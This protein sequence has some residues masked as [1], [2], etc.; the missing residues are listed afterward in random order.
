MPRPQTLGIDFGTSNSAAGVTV[1]DRPWLVELEPGETT[2]PTAIFFDSDTKQMRIGRSATRALV[3]GDEGRFMR[4]LKSLLGTP[5]LYEKRRLGGVMMDFTD[6]IAHFLREVKTRA[7]TAT[8]LEFSHALSGRP[9]KFHSKDEARNARAEEDLRACYLKAG[10][11]DVRFLNEPEAALRAARPHPGIG[12]V[13]DIGGGTSDF[14]CFEQTA[15]GGSTILASH[16]LR[17]GGTDFDRQ[18]SI[19]H[20]MPHLGRGAMIRNSFGS[21]TLPAPSR[22]FN[23]LATWAMIPFLYSADS[24]RAAQD[25]A[26]NAEDPTQLT[27]LVRVLDEEL[28]HDLAF[29]TEAGKIRANSNGPHGE[30]AMIDLRLI[31]PGLAAPLTGTAL[32][33]TLAAMVDDI[34]AEAAETLRL[35]NIAPDA[36]DRCVM[37]GGSAL[38]SAVRDA[39]QTLCPNA[40]IETER[41]MTAVA[42]GLALAAQ[43]AVF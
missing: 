25:L 1:A 24:R 3:E 2:L 22:M 7:E 13:V 39:M 36:V 34:R 35:A 17:L 42:D 23:D 28:G 18:I 29:A 41:A 30:A 11:A 32:N 21:G 5:L 19:D 26:R 8:R 6:V 16:G 10:F 31:D 15:T 33:Q 38:L 20:V 27:R 9:V 40:E 37:V 43:D 4:A 14:T 12:L